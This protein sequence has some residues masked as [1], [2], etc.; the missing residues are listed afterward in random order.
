MKSVITAL[1]GLYRNQNDLSLHSWFNRLT[2][3]VRNELPAIIQVLIE[4]EQE[5]E[6]LKERVVELEQQLKGGNGIGD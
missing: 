3:F 6:R 5:N 4:A 2:D 1:Q